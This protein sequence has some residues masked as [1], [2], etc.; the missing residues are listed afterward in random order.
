MPAGNHGGEEGAV[1]GR[2]SVKPDQQPRLWPERHAC[3]PHH[4]RRLERRS[5]RKKSNPTALSSQP[6][7]ILC[8][9][10]GPDECADQVFKGGSPAQ[11]WV[12]PILG[13]GWLIALQACISQG[14]SQ[15]DLPGS[16]GG[17]VLAGQ[18]GCVCFQRLLAT[19]ENLFHS[20]SMD[21]WSPSGAS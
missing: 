20:L 8:C 15:V 18:G 9:V 17:A 2:I 6:G 4:V 5:S 10:A 11:K 7:T 21:G 14:T 13:S 3:R 1:Q 16:G 12:H 19:A